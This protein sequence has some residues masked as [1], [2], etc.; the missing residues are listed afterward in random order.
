MT[1]KSKTDQK[2]KQLKVELLKEGFMKMLTP[3]GKKALKSG[4]LAGK[5]TGIS[6]EEDVNGRKKIVFDL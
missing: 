2:P 6:F 4:A 1:S 5:H 3:E